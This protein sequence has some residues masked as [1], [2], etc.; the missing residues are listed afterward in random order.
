MLSWRS[1]SIY[2]AVRWKTRVAA[3]NMAADTR[4]AGKGKPIKAPKL[5]TR[6][7]IDGSSL[8]Q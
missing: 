8:C 1:F 4:K 3:K 2:S 6:L 7:S 5:S